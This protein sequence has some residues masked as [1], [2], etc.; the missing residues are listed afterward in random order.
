MIDSHKGSHPCTPNVERIHH[1]VRVG[2]EQALGLRVGVKD[3]DDLVLRESGPEPRRVDDFVDLVVQQGS[4]EVLA[5]FTQTSTNASVQRVLDTRQKR[6]AES[7]AQAFLT[8][9]EP[10]PEGLRV[11]VESPRHQCLE[12]RPSSESMCSPVVPIDSNMELQMS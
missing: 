2:G 9:I 8:A 5:P 11:H 3:L 4:R 6:R 1:A 12:R 10:S 7:A